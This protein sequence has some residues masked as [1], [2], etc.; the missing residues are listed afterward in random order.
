MRAYVIIAILLFQSCTTKDKQSVTVTT[1]EPK[2]DISLLKGNWQY[3]DKYNNYI[4]VE[5]ADSVYH[6]VQYENDDYYG[7]MYPYAYRIVGDSLVFTSNKTWS[8]PQWILKALDS[9][10][11]TLANAHD[12]VVCRRVSVTWPLKDYNVRI[13]HN[14]YSKQFLSL[15]SKFK[16]R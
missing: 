8:N 14:K 16:L 10:E 15:R 2:Y 6:F 3:C 1:Q 4:L 13:N 7:P 5:F 11:M 9:T 12:T